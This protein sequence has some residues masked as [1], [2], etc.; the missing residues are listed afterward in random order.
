[1][2]PVP[3][4]F[5]F[6]VS[7]ITLRRSASCVADAASKGGRECEAFAYVS[8]PKKDNSC[9]SSLAFFFLDVAYSTEIICSMYEKNFS[10]RL[11]LTL[12]RLLQLSNFRNGLLPRNLSPYQ[13]RST[14]GSLV[15]PCPC[16]SNVYRFFGVAALRLSTA[17][18][19][20]AAGEGGWSCEAEVSS[21]GLV[22]GR[23]RS[24]VSRSRAS[25]RRIHTYSQHQTGE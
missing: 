3:C 14:K 11:R 15:S 18:A 9:R 20:H 4:V 1:M 19:K 12:L 25:Q 17:C 7:Y 8:N 2:S 13:A 23:V 21:G 16:L 6:P 5:V 22:C 24:L 10:D